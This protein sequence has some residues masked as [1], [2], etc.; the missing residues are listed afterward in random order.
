MGIST[1]DL[2]KRSTTCSKKA[3]YILEYFNSRPHEEV[4]R[5]LEGEELRKYNFNSRPHEEVD[6]KRKC[7][8]CLVSYFNSRPH[9]EVD[10]YAAVREHHGNI[11][12]HDLTKRS[13]LEEDLLKQIFYISTHDLT[14]R[15]T[16]YI[17]YD[18]PLENISTHDLT[19]RSTL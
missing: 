8:L 9:E 13:T 14:K 4:D 10:G 7:G 3:D 19:K 12:T 2:T 1:H 15:S 18:K 16:G 11:S 6:G 17:E 5:E